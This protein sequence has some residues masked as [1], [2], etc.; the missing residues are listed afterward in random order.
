MVRDIDV[1]K[2]FISKDSDGILF[3]KKLINKNGRLFYKGNARLNKLLHL[4]QNI[5]YAKTGTPLM[6]TTFYAYDNGAVIP[7]IQENYGALLNLPSYDVHFD[8]E[9]EDF[10]NRFFRAFK[11][12]SI[13]ELIE[14]SREDDEWERKHCFFNKEKQRMN[15]TENL[16]AYREQYADIIKII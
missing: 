1:A 9:I 4:A 8:T 11:N 7:R 14:L 5:Y 3:S 10:L 16:L 12:A 15:S 6:D 13:D 2:F